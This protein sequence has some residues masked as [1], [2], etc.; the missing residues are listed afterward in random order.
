MIKLIARIK[1]AVQGK[2]PLGSKRSSQW[3]SV[4]AAHLRL[5]PACEVCGGTKKL[6]AHHIKSF[7]EHPELELTPSNLL[8]LCDSNKRC[9]WAFGHLW[10]WK[11]TNQTAEEDAHY[12]FMRTQAHVS[13]KE[14]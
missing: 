8:T 3:R 9:H 10:N 7:H 14:K 5:S 11:K 13:E 4:R 12:W 6:E 1:D 2:A